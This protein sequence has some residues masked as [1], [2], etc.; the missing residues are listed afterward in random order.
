MTEQKQRIVGDKGDV[1]R[2]TTSYM[3][4]DLIERGS[5]NSRGACREIQQGRE[6][7]AVRL[8]SAQLLRVSGGA[9]G[10]LTEEKSRDPTNISL[11][12]QRSYLKPS[13]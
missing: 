5:R 9:G 3:R 12:D 8:M 2:S 7:L 6:R 13:Y 4:M 11:Q 10:P 1:E